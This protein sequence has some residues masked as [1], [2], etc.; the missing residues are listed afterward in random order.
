[1][2]II[3][4]QEKELLLANILKTIIHYSNSSHRFNKQIICKS[5]HNNSSNNQN[6]HKIKIKLKTNTY[7]KN[8]NMYLFNI[9]L[10]P[11]KNNHK[12]KNKVLFLEKENQKYTNLKQNKQLIKKNN[13]LNAKKLLNLYFNLFKLSKN[14]YAI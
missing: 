13:G 7:I 6:K 14:C 4:K 11:I 10:I 1:M 5:M 2:I 8:N 12:I 9:A 3:N